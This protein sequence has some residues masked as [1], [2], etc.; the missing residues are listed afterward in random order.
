[1]NHPRLM[2]TI[3]RFCV[4]QIANEQSA[5]EWRFYTIVHFLSIG[6]L[7]TAGTRPVVAQCVYVGSNGSYPITA[8]LGQPRGRVIELRKLFNS[9][10]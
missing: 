10:S 7:A 3:S 8:L 1:M 6:I 2:V 9:R 5:F 4:D